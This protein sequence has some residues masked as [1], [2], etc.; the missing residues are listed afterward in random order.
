MTEAEAIELTFCEKNK[1]IAIG[2]GNPLRLEDQKSGRPVYELLLRAAKAQ[3]KGISRALLNEIGSRYG[4]EPPSKLLLEARTA[5]NLPCGLFRVIQSRSKDKSFVLTAHVKGLGGPEAVLDKEDRV[6]VTADAAP[7]TSRENIVNDP[8]QDIAFKLVT[9]L[10]SGRLSSLGANAEDF[11]DSLTF[12]NTKYPEIEAFRDIPEHY[13]VWRT[14][15]TL[16]PYFKYAIEMN[17]NR[18]DLTPA[19]RQRIKGKIR[20]YVEQNFKRKYIYDSVKNYL[21][22]R[23]RIKVGESEIKINCYE[24]L[25][26]LILR[27]FNVKDGAQDRIE[28]KISEAVPKMETL[29]F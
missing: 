4:F 23:K 19:E 25:Q 10:N 8:M 18:P 12:G 24:D 15:G 2:G 7:D 17:I 20:S 13:F 26:D 14:L 27:Q 21:E 6:E 29:V 9:F 1:T 22:G 16:S 11:M 3:P 28:D 5:L